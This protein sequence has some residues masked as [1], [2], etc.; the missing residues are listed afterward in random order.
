MTKNS[1]QPSVKTHTFANGDPLPLLG[2]GTWKAAPGETYA[3]VREAIKV[4]YRHIDCAPLYGNEKEVG[5]AIRDAI[6]D[7]EVT[8]QDLFVTSKLWGN[9]HGEKNVEPQ[10]RRTLADLGLEYVDLYL[11]HWPIPLKPTVFVPE[12]GDDFMA[13]SDVPLAST[14]AGF[15]A[16]Q[17]AGL[18]RHIGVSNFSSTKLRALIATCKVKPEVN[19]I[20][21]HPL[22]Q[23][24]ELVHY[25]AS[26]NIHIT[27]YSPLGSNDRP[28]FVKEADAP[29]LLEDA[30]VGA[31]AK[32]HGATPAQVLLAWHVQRGMSTIPKSVKPARLR[33]NLAAAALELTMTELGQIAQLECGRRLV[34]CNFW[35]V[36]GSPWTFQ[37]IFDA[38]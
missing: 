18:A 7:G 19:Q 22:L 17:A 25:C 9:C 28:D 21:L 16:V 30:T 36:P 38:P 13:P 34:V 4:G 5:D 20:E 33:E 6:K 8:R 23:Q 10:L 24:A 29:V 2:L 1:T 37:S 35:V 15:E 27:A 26:E 12:K 14:W 11:V 3:T 31:I 32:A